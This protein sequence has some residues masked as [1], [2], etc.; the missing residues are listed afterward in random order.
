[1]ATEASLDGGGVAHRT[2]GDRSRVVRQR[3]GAPGVH[4]SLVTRRVANA[5]IV[6]I[7]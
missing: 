1:M 7:R 2:Q 5:G 6:P 4:E 3:D